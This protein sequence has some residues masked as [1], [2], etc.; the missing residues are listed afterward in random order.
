[1]T[2]A[3]IMTKKQECAKS[4]LHGPLTGLLRGDEPTPDPEV[5]AWLPPST[6][7]RFITSTT[8]MLVPEGYYLLMRYQYAQGIVEDVFLMLNPENEYQA[9][10]SLTNR[11]R[12][13][14]SGLGRNKKRFLLC[15]TV[16]GG[17]LRRMTYKMAAQEF[18]QM[19][20]LEGGDRSAKRAS[21]AEGPADFYRDLIYE[22]DSKVVRR[23]Y[24]GRTSPDEDIWPS[25]GDEPD[26]LD[27]P[28]PC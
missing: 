28:P 24:A 12:G 10:R 2:D 5:V 26:Q 16:P 27:L 19:E 25:S 3:N 8:P 21:A 17:P 23:Y 6:E 20:A 1:M 14:L 9:Q 15:A 13:W 22:I 4:E 18:W 11:F 7:P